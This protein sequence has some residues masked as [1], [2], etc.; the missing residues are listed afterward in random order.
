MF[1]AVRNKEKEVLRNCRKKRNRNVGKKSG[2]F[3]AAIFSSITAKKVRPF[4]QITIIIFIFL[5]G[6][7]FW[8]CRHYIDI[9]RNTKEEQIERQKDTKRQIEKD[10]QINR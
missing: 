2:P 5:S 10:K 4:S 8:N 3:L 7:G 1:A 9:E 6:L